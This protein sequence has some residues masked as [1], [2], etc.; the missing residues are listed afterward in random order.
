M[1]LPAHA[2][3]NAIY[4]ENLSNMI[5]YVVYKQKFIFKQLLL[6]NNC[7]STFH[8]KMMA[9]I[10]HRYCFETLVVN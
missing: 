5:T 3:F 9:E 7:I 2:I 10:L 6:K 8:F 4:G 1:W